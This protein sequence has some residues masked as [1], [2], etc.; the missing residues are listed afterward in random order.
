MIRIAGAFVAITIA[1]TATGCTREATEAQPKVAEQAETKSGE[2]DASALDPGN[3]P[4]KPLPPMGNGGDRQHVAVLEAN[5]I[6]DVVV[7]PWEVDPAIKEIKGIGFAS[8]GSPILP[9]KLQVVT[10]PEV[11]DAGKSKMV[12]GFASNRQQKGQKMLINVVLEMQDPEAATAAAHDMRQRLLDF[13]AKYESRQGTAIVAIPG[14]DDT[15]AVASTS[16]YPD[17]GDRQWNMVESF[18]PRGRF[19][20]MQRAE[21]IT[22][23]D[24]AVALVAKTLD[25][26]V[27]AIDSFTPTAPADLANLPKDPSGLLA[28]ALPVP[29]KGEKFTNNA[30]MGAHGILHYETDPLAAGKLY[31]DAGVDVAVI[32]DG[33]LSRTRDNA[34][35]ATLA[36]ALQDVEGPGAMTPVDAVPNL[37]GS[38][39]YQHSVSKNFAC[40]GSFDRYAF[41][42]VGPRLKDA[43]QKAAAQYLILAAK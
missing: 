26:Q 12:T 2:V 7:G 23:M 22:N 18:T 17:T 6:A 10:E 21:T 30:T 29:A 35:A 33:S 8:G 28:R 39:C 41:A 9:E 25:L 19:V 43:Q 14:H 37:P 20:L 5:R 24:E 3:Y 40:T 15:V 31:G 1:V 4:T 36:A 38:H 13:A 42:V 27:P 34:T 32:A 16:V 11:A